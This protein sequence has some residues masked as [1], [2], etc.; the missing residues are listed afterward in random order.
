[1][2]ESPNACTVL[3][4]RAPQQERPRIHALGVHG[5]P[6]PAN[7]AGRFGLY[8]SPRGSAT[9]RYEDFSPLKRPVLGLAFQS[10]SMRQIWLRYHADPERSV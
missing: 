5:L 1:M 2:S 4:E 3:G 7:R 9:C 10:A 6:K 8:A